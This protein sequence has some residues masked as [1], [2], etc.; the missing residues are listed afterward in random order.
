MCLSV[1]LCLTP[2]QMK[3]GRPEF[4]YTDSPLPCLK[5]FFFKSTGGEEPVC[6]I[7]MFTRIYVYVFVRVTHPDV[8]KNDTDTKFGALLSGLYPK[9]FFVL[10]EKYEP[11]SY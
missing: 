7:C 1:Y 4:R 9:S 10:L 3:N 11:E 5:V 2:D 6:D 8:R